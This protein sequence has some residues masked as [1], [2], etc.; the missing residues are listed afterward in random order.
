MIRSMLAYRPADRPS[1]TALLGHA[2]LAMHSAAGAKPAVAAAAG[3]GAI[4]LQ[5][6]ASPAGG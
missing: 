6:F 5:A 1:A 3:G 2:Y 4:S